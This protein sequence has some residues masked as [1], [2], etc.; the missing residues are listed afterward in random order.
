MSYFPTTSTFRLVFQNP[1][2]PEDQEPA[3]FPFLVD[4]DTTRI[5]PTPPYTHDDLLFAILGDVHCS[6]VDAWDIGP[7]QRVWTPDTDTPFLEPGKIFAGSAPLHHPT[8]TVLPGGLR[9]TILPQGLHYGPPN[10]HPCA[11]V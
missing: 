3:E 1:H 4:V 6:W 9:T 8:G 5:T 10:R 11:P 2:H 7:L